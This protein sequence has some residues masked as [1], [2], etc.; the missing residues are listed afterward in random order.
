MQLSSPLD[1]ML[2]YV[3]VYREVELLLP[4]GIKEKLSADTIS[5]IALLISPSPGR[6]DG[7]AVKQHPWFRDEAKE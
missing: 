3:K 6:R 5:L 4:K 7:K 2:A 1:V